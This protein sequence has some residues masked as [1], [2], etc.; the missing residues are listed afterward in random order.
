[1]TAGWDGDAPLALLDSS[2]VVRAKG[3]KYASLGQ[4]PRKRDAQNRERQ[5]CES[6]SRIET[7]AGQGGK[8]ESGFQPL[9]CVGSGTWGVAP[10]WDGDAPLALRAFFILRMHFIPLRPDTPRSADV[11]PQAIVRQPA[12]EA[13]PPPSRRVVVWF[14]VAALYERRSL[15][16]AVIDRRYNFPNCTTVSP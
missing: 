6:S 1:M 15:R 7:G 11:S 10:G 12:G 2:V 3:P 5:R 8:H 9:A 13:S 4:R 14:A 16:T